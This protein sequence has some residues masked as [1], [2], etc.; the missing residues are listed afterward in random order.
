MADK[1]LA[2]LRGIN[3]GGKNML[4]MKD[5]AAMFSKAGCTQIQTYIQSGNVIFSVADEIATTICPKIEKQIPFQTTIILRSLPEVLQAAGGNPYPD[6]DNS[7]IMFL[8]SQPS[9]EQVAQLDPN[10]GAP[11]RF[12][13]VGKHI[14]LHLPNGTARSKLTNAYFDSKLKTVS[15]IRNWRTLLKLLAMMAG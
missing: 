10:R 3:V 2:L 8:A 15:T 11:D 1:Y 14:Y 7:H 12:T 13:V 4:P 6:I 9:A 5:L